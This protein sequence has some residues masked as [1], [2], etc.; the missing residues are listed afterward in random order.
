MR[1]PP[2]ERVRPGA[3][4]GESLHGARVQRRA[5]QFYAASLAPLP[6]LRTW[7]Y[8]RG[9]GCASASPDL[10]PQVGQ[11][12]GHLVVILRALRGRFRPAQSFIS[13]GMI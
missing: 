2:A 8:E 7:P 9:Q 3:E 6:T 13:D 10:A 12:Q 4:S 5:A 1:S 11:G